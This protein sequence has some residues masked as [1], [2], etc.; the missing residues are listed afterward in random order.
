MNLPQNKRPIMVEF[1]MNN[2]TQ[3]AN[4]RQTVVKTAIR[5]GKSG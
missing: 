4:K 1:R 3:E 2:I 5:K